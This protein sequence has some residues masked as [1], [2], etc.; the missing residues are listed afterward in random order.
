MGGTDD[1]IP[2]R[3]PV[4]DCRGDQNL[5]FGMK[6]RKLFQEGLMFISILFDR[7]PYMLETSREMPWVSGPYKP[8][9][10]EYVKQLRIRLG[11]KE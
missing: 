3:R 8:D 7:L 6:R 4:Q 2:G 11:V 1:R 10:L 9:G 5:G